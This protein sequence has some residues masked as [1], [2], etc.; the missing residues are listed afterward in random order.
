MDRGA[1]GIFTRPE[2]QSPDSRLHAQLKFINSGLISLYYYG[3]EHPPKKQLVE[4]DG[5]PELLPHSFV[6]TDR[7]RPL[8]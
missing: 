2:V 8:I 3:M 7:P 5:R 6:S 1:S 4:D